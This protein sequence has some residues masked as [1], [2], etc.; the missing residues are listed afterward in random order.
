M[1]II[2]RKEI[3][4]GNLKNEQSV[5]VLY[6]ALSNLTIFYTQGNRFH[7]FFSIIY[8]SPVRKPFQTQLMQ[9]L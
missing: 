9:M 3:A 8:W 4:E 5:L 7:Y 2:T 1:S 6:R